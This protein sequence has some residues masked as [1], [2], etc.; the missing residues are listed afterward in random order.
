MDEP[1]RITKPGIYTPEQIP[2]SAYVADP[3]PEPSLTKGAVN[4]LD[5]KTAR[6][7][8][9]RH[10][11]LGGKSTYSRTAD[12]GSAAHSE[13]L[14]DGEIVWI[15]ADAYRSNDAKAARDAAYADGKIPM[16]VKEK[17]AIEA[18]AEA[19]RDA[20]KRRFGSLDFLPEQTLI[21]NEN[22]VWH[23][24][25]PDIRYPD[26]NVVVEFK[27]STSAN[28]EDFKRNVMFKMAYDNQ[29]G[30][31]CR[32][33]DQLGLGRPRFFWLVEEVEAPHFCSLIEATDELLFNAERKIEWAQPIWRNCLETGHWPDYIDEDFTATP[34]PWEL[35]R[36]DFKTGL[37]ALTFDG[38]EI[39]D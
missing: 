1:L 18:M 27:T 11:R 31:C 29:A 19:A 6:H 30:M 20:L 5:R 16:L 9:L 37:G 13:L 7:A 25:R 3:C 33:H 34:P 35:D 17:A 12:R 8:Y 23:K 28:P 32:G 14:G 24:S 26:L 15:K 39:G 36:V 21:W 38:I 22:G 2:M 4:D 10:P